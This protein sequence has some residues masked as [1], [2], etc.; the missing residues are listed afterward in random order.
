MRL[1]GAVL[2]LA[3]CAGTAF[4][5]GGAFAR[6]RPL[7]VACALLAPVAVAVAVLGA[8]LVFVPGFLT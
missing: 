6:R 5:V 8:V 2:F 3:G 7:D 4:A 1:L